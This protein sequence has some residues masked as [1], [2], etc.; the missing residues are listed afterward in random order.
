[1][2]PSSPLPRLQEQE[3]EAPSPALQDLWHY[4]ARYP[5]DT[6][7]YT[8]EDWCTTDPYYLQ[9]GVSLIT[10]VVHGQ[11]LDQAQPNFGRFLHARPLG[12]QGNPL[13][14]LRESVIR[15]LNLHALA[16][17]WSLVARV[18]GYDPD[19]LW[20]AWQQIQARQAAEPDLGIWDGDADIPARGEISWT[21]TAGQLRMTVEF[22]S[23]TTT[24]KDLQINP[25]LYFLMGVEEYWICDPATQRIRSVWRF[26]EAGTWEDVL[27]DQSPEA[28]T[29]VYSE[30]LQTWVRFDPDYGLQCQDPDTG[31]WISGDWQANH[32]EGEKNRHVTL[33]LSAVR[34][35][36]PDM[37]LRLQAELQ[38][39]LQQRPLDTLPDPNGLWAHMTALPAEA[40]TE[41][42]VLD[43]LGVDR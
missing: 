12:P 4:D 28:C 8:Y 7:A 27:A 23:D 37:S 13:Q 21:M 29:E 40:R 34:H 25:V 9:D 39:T 20:R 11:S 15:D 30:V 1:M 35:L 32:R 2:T 41:H 14:C 17:D 22:L 6:A 19:V 33:L 38:A 18:A 24:S 5:Y 26:T 36:V 42:A 43:F 31:Q 16:P 10:D 3:L